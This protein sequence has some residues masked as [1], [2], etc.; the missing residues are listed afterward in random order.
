LSGENVGLIPG[1]FQEASLYIRD[2]HRVVLKRKTGFIKYALQFGYKVVPV[3]VFG[4]EK[5]LWKI[6]LFPKR[7]A[8][9]LNKFNIPATVFY[10]KYGLLPDDDI[11][12]RV[13]VGEPLQMP[14]IPEPTAEDVSKHHDAYVKAL[15]SL[16]DKH[17]KSNGVDAD[18]ELEIL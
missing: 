1:G 4:E 6:D 8:L 3:Y 12:V 15:K 14:T 18:V 16:F 2:R 10:G 11:D 17:K 7:F 13:V 9:W 5:T